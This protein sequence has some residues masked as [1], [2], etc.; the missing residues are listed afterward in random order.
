MAFASDVTFNSEV[1]I[2]TLP[3]SVISYI[4]S[5]SICVCGFVHIVDSILV[6]FSTLSVEQAHTQVNVGE[7]SIVY[8]KLFSCLQ[9]SS[10]SVQ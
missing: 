4:C 3:M 8:F 2:Q 7:L 10:C 5:S 6:F 9:F 1:Y